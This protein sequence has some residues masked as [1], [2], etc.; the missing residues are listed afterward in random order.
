MGWGGMASGMRALCLELQASFPPPRSPA[1]R[2]LGLKQVRLA[3][4]ASLSDQ[5][6][7]HFQTR[8]LFLYL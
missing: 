5:F 2:E 8:M 6:T 1:L 3:D 4:G 7:L